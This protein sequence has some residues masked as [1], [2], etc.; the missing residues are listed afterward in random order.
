MPT[1]R[2]RIV[3]NCEIANQ[4]AEA[5]IYFLMLPDS[6]S[7]YPEECKK[8]LNDSLIWA[9]VKSDS[10]WDG[11]GFTVTYKPWESHEKMAQAKPVQ[12]SLRLDL[13]FLNRSVQIIIKGGDCWT[14]SVDNTG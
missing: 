11:Q 7:Y 14:K 4:R 13:E 6:I 10:I 8:A 5:L 1:L 12:D 2:S 3:L 9:S